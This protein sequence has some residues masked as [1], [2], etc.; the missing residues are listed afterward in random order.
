M[1]ILLAVTPSRNQKDEPI[2]FL[3]KAVAITVSGESSKVLYFEDAEALRQFLEQIQPAAK[4]EQ[5][6]MPS[7]RERSIFAI[8]STYAD[9]E[10][11]ELWARERN[12]HL[13]TSGN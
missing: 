13:P 7:V 1:G 9:W 6:W 5:L 10:R 11:L 4:V 12:H 8:R 3:I 2:A